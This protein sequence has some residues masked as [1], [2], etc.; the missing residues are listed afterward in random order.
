MNLI[1]LLHKLESDL[2]RDCAQR[3]LELFRQCYGDR[4]DR[5]TDACWQHDFNQVNWKGFL[6]RPNE[7]VKEEQ[8]SVA[9][10]REKTV[11]AYAVHDTTS[12]PVAIYMNELVNLDQLKSKL[13]AHFGF[14][15][16]FNESSCELEEEVCYKKTNRLWPFVVDH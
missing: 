11:A 8:E 4:F 14:E 10:N 1:E 7:H 5:V 2:D 15:E 6:L 3:Y 9:I 12:E 16:T 13:L